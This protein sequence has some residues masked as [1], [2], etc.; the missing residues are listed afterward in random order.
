M[1]KLYFTV[2]IVF[3]T[4]LTFAQK[5]NEVRA[6]MG[7]DFVSVPSLTDYLQANYTGPISSFSSAV[8]FSGSYGR[9]ISVNGQLEGEISYLLNSYNSTLTG[10]TYDLTY[11]LIMPSVLYYYVLHGSGYY[12]KF[13]GGG[14]VRFLSVNEK[15]PADPNKYNYSSIGYGFILR[16]AGN[17]AISENVYAYISTDIRY[18]FIKE[19]Q[20]SSDQNFIGNV[21][22]NSLSL[23]VRLGI[24]YQ[25]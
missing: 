9:L 19:P 20:P 12:F 1:K 3:F 8:N 15:L 23:G 25:F 6:S 5:P 17:T 13:G 10:G 24:S 14:G 2:L 4:S 7:I 16:A 18:D 22:F 21:S 11:N